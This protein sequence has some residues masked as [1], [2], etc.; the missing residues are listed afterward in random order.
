M[1]ATYDEPKG[2]FLL[3]AL[4]NGVPVVQPERGAFPE[5]VSKTGGGLL[6]AAD[7]PAALADGILDV[8]ARSGAG[9]CAGRAGARGVREH[10]DVGVMAEA[11][12]QAYRAADR[13]PRID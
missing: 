6:V 5:I 13:E 3:E 7:D 9:G 1:P 11:A 10:Y 8:V 4:A 12:E 2:M